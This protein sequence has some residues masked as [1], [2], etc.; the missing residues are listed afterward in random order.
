MNK[1]SKEWTISSGRQ[2][3]TSAM[4]GVLLLMWDCV[5]PLSLRL[6]DRDKRVE[7]NQTLIV[8]NHALAVP[9]AARLLVCALRTCCQTAVFSGLF[10]FYL[11]CHYSVW[12]L[13]W[14]GHCLWMC[15]VHLHSRIKPPEGEHMITQVGPTQRAP[16]AYHLDGSTIKHDLADIMGFNH[17]IDI[18]RWD[19]HLDTLSTFFFLWVI[20]STF[21]Y[22]S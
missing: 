7:C 13:W 19:T 12:I 9:V 4:S 22:S 16:D 3:N 20:S 8:R 11:F 5:V 1:Q 17:E 14:I 21:L 18:S 2:I 15:V 6:I 10:S